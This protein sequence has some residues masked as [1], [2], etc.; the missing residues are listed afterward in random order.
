MTG[1]PTERASSAVEARLPAAADLDAAAAAPE[2]KRRVR[3]PH[4]TK[5][6]AAYAVLA[7]ALVGAAAGLAFLLQRPSAAPEP[8]W[9][10]WTPGSVAQM[11]RAAEIAVQVS[12]R[13]RLPSGHQLVG[14]RALPMIVQDIPVDAIAVEEPTATPDQQDISFVPAKGSL[15]Y[16][17]CGL[18]P[19]CT[20]AEGQSSAERGILV[21][22]EALELALTTFKYVQ[23]I[24]SVVILRPP[25]KATAK[26]QQADV[27]VYAL[28]FRHADLQSELD[29]PLRATLPET[30]RL[31]PGS[32]GQAEAGT[33]DALT[34][35]R[36]FLFDSYQQGPDGRL[37]MI[38]KHPSLGK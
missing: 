2:A 28:L 36:Q 14:A 3:G 21:N 32:I 37:Y 4:G 13:Y 7:L 24:D 34:A 16:V 22:R 30:G 8:P 35:P 11:D 29:R 17:L 23:G 31:R 18:G 12:T 25:R 5:F 9:S 10:A 19:S 27:P 1:K 6:V 26:E 15:E 38:L 33:I 20:I